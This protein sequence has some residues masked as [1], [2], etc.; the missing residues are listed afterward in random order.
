MKIDRMSPE[1]HR[2]FHGR[3]VRTGRCVLE[4]LEPKEVDCIE[5]FRPFVGEAVV[6][7]VDVILNLYGL[8]FLTK[9]PG[10]IATNVLKR[11]KKKRLKSYQ[12]VHVY[13][14]F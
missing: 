9:R 1:K 7:M 11:G 2:K 4:T 10:Q 14:A 8:V 5:G 12:M 6:L 13:V 3:T